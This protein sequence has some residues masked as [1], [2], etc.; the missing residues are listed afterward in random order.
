MKGQFA[1]PY[2]LAYS[3]MKK[4]KTLCGKNSVRFIEPSIGLGA[5]YA[6][7]RGVFEKKPVTHL[8]LR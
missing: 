8:V 7:F 4:A 1:T 6:A 5:F 3:I 2:P